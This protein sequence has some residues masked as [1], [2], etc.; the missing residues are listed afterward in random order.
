MRVLF[1]PLCKNRMN[2][3]SHTG[4][5]IMV[6]LFKKYIQKNPFNLIALMPSV[7]VFVTVDAGWRIVFLRL[8]AQT[9]PWRAGP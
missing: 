5:G 2:D 9:L 4:G 8:S 3:A 1:D 6:R 7:W